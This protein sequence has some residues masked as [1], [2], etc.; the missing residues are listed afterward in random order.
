MQYLKV[1]PAVL[2]CVV[3]ASCGGSPA[4]TDSAP[5]TLWTVIPTD[6][7]TVAPTIEPTSTAAPTNTPAPTNTAAPEATIAARSGPVIPVVTCVGGC[8]TPPDAS[9]TIKG[10]ISVSSGERIYHVPGQAFYDETEIS[11]EYGERWFCTEDEATEAGWRK[12]KR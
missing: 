12:A 2:V 11:P 9:C 5:S 6:A 10:N 1:I 8:V 7:P 4:P 3:L